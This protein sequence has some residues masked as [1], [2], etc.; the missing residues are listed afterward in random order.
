MDAWKRAIDD[1]FAIID[2]GGA[3]E[4]QKHAIGRVLQILETRVR[5]QTAAPKSL[6]RTC[7]GSCLSPDPVTLHGRDH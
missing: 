5:V 3:A 1:L 4:F 7:G 2:D 6:C